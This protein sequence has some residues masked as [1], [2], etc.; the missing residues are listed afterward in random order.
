MI[1]SLIDLVVDSACSLNDKINCIL[2]V[3]KSYF[4]HIDTYAPDNMP[5]F[6]DGRSYSY[7][8]VFVAVNLVASGFDIHQPVDQLAFGIV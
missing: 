8:A 1:V 2:L 5:S 3:Y 6:E 4:R 7:N